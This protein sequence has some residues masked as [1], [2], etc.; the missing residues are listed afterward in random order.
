M[1]SSAPAPPDPWES[2]Q[3]QAELNRQAMLDS[4][5]FNQYGEQTPYG[6][7]HWVG[8]IG[9]PSRRRVYTMSPVQQ[10]LFDQQNRIKFDHLGFASKRL[11][12]LQAPPN[13]PLSLI[14][15]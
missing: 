12:I 7:S 11:P 3:A 14:H 4:S 1:G 6:T 8:E 10:A 5:R 13:T 15:I 2:S 9:T